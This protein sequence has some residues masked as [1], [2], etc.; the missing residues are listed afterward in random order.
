MT[1]GGYTD[2][3][4]PAARTQARREQRVRFAHRCGWQEI[5][6]RHLTFEPFGAV[7]DERDGTVY[8]INRG[9]ILGVDYSNIT[10]FYFSPGGDP[11]FLERRP[12]SQR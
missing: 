10:A 6:R 3:A 9:E 2:E 1:I 11:N 5:D 7:I 12:G 8:M 4:D